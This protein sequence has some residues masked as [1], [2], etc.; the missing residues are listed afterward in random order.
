MT[1]AEAKIYHEGFLEEINTSE[2]E[3][4]TGFINPSM[5][6]ITYWYS[7]WREENLGPRQ[8]TGVI[9]VS[10]FTNIFDLKTAVFLAFNQ[11]SCKGYFCTNA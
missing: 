5:N 2:A 11:V 3:F 7:K 9:K 10:K 8:G 4:A 6:T 1:A